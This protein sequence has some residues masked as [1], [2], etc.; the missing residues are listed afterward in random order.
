MIWGIFG[1]KHKKHLVHYE[2]FCREDELERIEKLLKDKLVGVSFSSFGISERL[3][4]DV[5]YPVMHF[6]QE[7]TEHVDFVDT[8]NHNAYIY[9]RN[10][11]F[12]E[13]GKVAQ[14]TFVRFFDSKPEILSILLHQFF[15]TDPL[16][17][18]LISDKHC[19][20]ET[21]IEIL[22]SVHPHARLV[23]SGD[24]VELGPVITT[25]GKQASMEEGILQEY[26]DGLV[27]FQHVEQLN[28]S[29][30]AKLVEAMDTGYIYKKVSGKIFK[31][32]SKVSVLGYT[33]PNTS[34]FV[35]KHTGL[36]KQQLPMQLELMEHFHMVVCVRCSQ[37]GCLA[38]LSY[39]ETDMDF[40]QDYIAYAATKQI[41]FPRKFDKHVAD[42]HKLVLTKREKY[43]PPI[44][45]NLAIAVIRLSVAHARMHLRDEVELSDLKYAMDLLQESLNLITY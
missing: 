32:P 37:E 1:S 9:Y 33:Q 39:S 27:A 17:V 29:A 45:K 21:L 7:H 2:S 34:V 11:I 23:K 31:P 25:Q 6:L 26:T 28:K 38:P 24:S 3:A 20:T 44:T 41:V 22:L 15:S 16:H 12:A 14:E 35:G 4:K 40:V 30:Q 5:S 19:H 10:T 18:M 36:F 8:L 43:I 42:W 13:I